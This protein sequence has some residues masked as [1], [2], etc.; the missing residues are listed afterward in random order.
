MPLVHAVLSLLESGPS[1]GY[2]LKAAFESR[3]GPQW[4]GL[5]IGHVYQILDRAH[6][7]GLIASHREPQ[8][9]K[10]DRVIHELTEL[11][12]NE[13]AR[14]LHE[15][16]VRQGG[17][18]DDFFLKLVAAKHSRDPELLA[19]VLHRQRAHLLGQLRDLGQLRRDSAAN[20][21]VVDLLITAAEL[22]VR[23]DLGLIDVAEEKTWL[24]DAFEVGTVTPAVRVEKSRSQ[25]L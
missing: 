1:H 22:H 11:G 9:V 20:N 24:P 21:P 17:Y 6:R 16:S 15:P 3:V 10:P 5:N 23:A 8:Q 2:E 12:R 25:V 19:G 14:W 18:R 4:G 7:D 13:L